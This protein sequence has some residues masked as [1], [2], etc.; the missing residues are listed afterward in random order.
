M[1]SDSGFTSGITN[2]VCSTTLNN[3][4][5]ITKE[6]L[7]QLVEPMVSSLILEFDSYEFTKNCWDMG[8]LSHQFLGFK[9]FLP[10]FKVGGSH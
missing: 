7:A 10:K 6:S 3:I 8:Q 9:Q 5:G 4:V 2:I 1:P